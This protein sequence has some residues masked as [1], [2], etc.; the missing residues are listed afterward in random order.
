MMTACISCL[1]MLTAI[2]ILNFNTSSVHSCKILPC[3]LVF[4]S[5]FVSKLRIDCRKLNLKEIRSSLRGLII[6]IGVHPI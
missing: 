3:N 1:R 5:N 2:S 4:T 6:S